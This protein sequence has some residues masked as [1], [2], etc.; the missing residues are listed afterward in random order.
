MS[1]IR[2]LAPFRYKARFAVEPLVELGIG[3]MRGGQHFDGDDPIEP[4]V[5]SLVDFAHP[6]GPDQR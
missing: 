2:A 4:R 1:R 3:G 6:T 5:L